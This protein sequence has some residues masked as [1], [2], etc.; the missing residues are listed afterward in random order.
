MMKARKISPK[1]STITAHATEVSLMLYA[2]DKLHTDEE[3]PKYFKKELVKIQTTLK[4]L[5]EEM[6]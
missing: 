6:G 4:L 5:S 2:I 3:I 1:Y